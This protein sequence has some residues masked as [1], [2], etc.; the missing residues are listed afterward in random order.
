MGEREGEGTAFAGFAFDPDSTAVVFDD[1]PADGKAEAG[2]FGLVSERVANLFELLEDLGLICW[3]DADAGVG[4]AQD[5]FA[6]A[7]SGGAG[8]GA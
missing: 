7:T 6:A 1:L 2:A 4:D 5:E 3:G 8:D